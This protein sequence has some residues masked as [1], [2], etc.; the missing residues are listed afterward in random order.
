[1]S[2]WPNIAEEIFE[3]KLDSSTF[4]EIHLSYF[5]DSLLCMPSFHILNSYMFLFTG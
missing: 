5:S 1:M 3:E 4:I 2:A